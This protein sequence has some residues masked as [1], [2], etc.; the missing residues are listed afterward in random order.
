MAVGTVSRP[1]PFVMPK[2]AARPLMPTIMQPLQMV[3]LV[4][5]YARPFILS[6]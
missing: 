4:N 1:E 6:R 2:V 3:V 5:M